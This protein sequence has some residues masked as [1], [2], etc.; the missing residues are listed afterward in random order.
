MSFSGSPNNFNDDELFLVGCDDSKVERNSSSGFYSSSFIQ[1]SIKS[2]QNCGV[3]ALY[4]L[5]S[6]IS[7]LLYNR[8]NYIQHIKHTKFIK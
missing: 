8:A 6:L 7:R 4:M 1:N 5:K 3:L 2:N